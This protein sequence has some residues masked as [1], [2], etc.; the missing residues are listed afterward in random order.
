MPLSAST[1]GANIAQTDGDNRCMLRNDNLVS[2]SI[3]C[4]KED[5]TPVSE[6]HQINLAVERRHG[7]VI[8]SN[9]SSQAL[10]EGQGGILTLGRDGAGAGVVVLCREGEL[11]GRAVGA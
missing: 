5:L 11:M 9:F 2:D 4:A 8:V 7:L 3:L 6:L 10:V 1:S